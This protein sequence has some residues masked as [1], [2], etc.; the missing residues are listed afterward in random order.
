M[1]TRKIF[2]L[3][4]LLLISVVNA[5]ENNWNYDLKKV[6]ANDKK[7]FKENLSKQLNLSDNSR[8]QN[9]SKV[10]ITHKRYL[11]PESENTLSS[12]LPITSITSISSHLFPFGEEKDAFGIGIDLSIINA[13][14]DPS[15]VTNVDSMIGPL[16]LS[17]RKLLWTSKGFDLEAY[18]RIDLS[19]MSNEELKD[20][21]LGRDIYKLG[22]TFGKRSKVF[23]VENDLEYIVDSTSTQKIGNIE[24]RYDFGSIITARMNVGARISAFHLGGYIEMKLANNFKASGG[25]FYYETGRNRIVSWG[26]EVSF[27]SNGFGL[28]L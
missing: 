9:P 22:M 1:K 7:I 17:L 23:Y 27:K 4:L 25:S 5:N 18:G 28:R 3:L 2:L 6:L 21:L 16:G 19:S 13:E 20:S 14:K 15:D 12:S 10:S 8:L 11:D 26:P 24:Y